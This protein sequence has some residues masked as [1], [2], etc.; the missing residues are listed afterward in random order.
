MPNPMMREDVY[1]SGAYVSDS[2]P[3]TI[4]GAIN[5]T[6]ILLVIVAISGVL[7]WQMYFNG[8]A[9]KT[10]MMIWAGVICG[11]ILALI[12]AFR[13][14][15]ANVLAPAYAVCEGFALGGLSAIYEKA[16]SGI[17]PS[18]VMLTFL[19]LFTMLFMYKFNVIRA[20]D[21]FRKTIM[22]ATISVGLFY[23]ISIIAGF[24]GKEFTIL[25]DSSPIGIGLSLLILGIACLNFII[26]FDFIERGAQSYAPKSFEWYGAFS[27]LVTLVWVYLEI[28]R[29]LARLRDR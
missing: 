11:F 16:L 6:L 24:F 27:L 5:K 29:L 20:T 2:T 3:M 15:N 9:D 23:L 10:M 25:Y 28:L 22:I 8:Y 18:A 14:Q 1:Q 17:V 7:T 13:P 4:S 12:T 21:K 19:A 26:D